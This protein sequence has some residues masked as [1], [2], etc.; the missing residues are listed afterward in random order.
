M[1]L[2]WEDHAWVPRNLGIVTF[3]ATVFANPSERVMQNKT[4]TTRR[5]AKIV[6]VFLPARILYLFDRKFF[7]TMMPCNIDHYTDQ[8]KK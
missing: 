3:F 1:G 8:H 2:Q 5:A 7:H 6:N 4:S